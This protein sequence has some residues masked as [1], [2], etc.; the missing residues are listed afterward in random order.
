MNIKRS[1]ILIVVLLLTACGGAQQ[2]VAPPTADPQIEKGRQVFQ[3]NC[4]ACHATAADTIVIGPSLH[5]IATTAATRREGLGAREYIEL[6]ILSPDEIV[7]EGYPDIMPKTFGTTL[8]GEEFDALVA[9]LLT[10]E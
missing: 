9:Y 3:L 8:S 2:T 1:F 10:L 4:A 7:T 6:S 5:G